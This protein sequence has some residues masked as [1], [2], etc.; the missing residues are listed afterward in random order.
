MICAP[1]VHLLTSSTEHHQVR[2]ADTTF[3]GHRPYWPTWHHHLATV[4][5]VRCGCCD[6]PPHPSSPSLRPALPFS[7]TP[8]SCVCNLLRNTSSPPSHAR[9]DITQC[10]CVISS[11]SSF[12]STSLPHSLVQINTPTSSRSHDALWVF[13][14]C[15]CAVA[16]PA[17]FDLWVG[18]FSLL[19]S[20]CLR[21]C[22]SITA[23][24]VFPEAQSLWNLEHQ[25]KKV[26]W[27][28]IWKN[29]RLTVLFTDCVG[30]CTRAI[31]TRTAAS[32]VGCLNNSQGILLVSRLITWQALNLLVIHPAAVG[33]LDQRYI[34][35]Y[36][37]TP[38]SS[39]QRRCCDW[40]FLRWW[41][42]AAAKCEDIREPQA[43]IS[44][45]MFSPIIIIIFFFT[46]NKKNIR[47]CRNILTLVLSAIV[48]TRWSWIKSSS[49]RAQELE[50]IVH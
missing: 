35:I 43:E 12:S 36:Q 32:G 22:I 38:N 16:E 46:M 29:K 48:W 1:S 10:G 21:T 30:Q 18:V 2:G 3:R 4:S 49:L 41:V 11:I 34:W 6:P 19:Y 47:L 31:P 44:G 40:P 45:K 7:S 39:R 37:V 23:P 33:D 50:R 26:R 13:S 25:W 5:M 28:D 20:E 14:S 17:G 9:L 8:L 24:Q 27:T 15:C 42:S